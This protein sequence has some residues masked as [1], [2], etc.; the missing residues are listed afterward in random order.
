MLKGGFKIGS[1]CVLVLASSVIIAQNVGVGTTTPAA[2]LHVEVP[3]GFSSPLMQVNVKGSTPY[4]I[5]LPNGKVGIGV[6]TP[7]E[8][9]DVAGNIQFSGA[10]MPGGNA[11]TAG[12]V[13]VSQ[14]PGV[15]PQWQ[16]LSLPSQGDSVCS[17]ALSNYLQK[18]TG[19]ELCN[20]VI[21]DDG[22]NVGIG[23]T[24]PAATLDINGNVR[25]RTINTVAAATPNDKILVANSTGDVL[26]IQF[27]GSNSDYLRGDGTWGAISGGDNWGTQVA[28]TQ[29]PLTGDGT[30]LNPITVQS[31][32]SAGDILVWDGTQWQIQQPSASSGITPICSS[33]TTNF[34]QKWTGTNICNSQIFDD[35]T[36]V[37]I[38]TTT[39]AAKLDVQGT[40]RFTGTLTIGAYTLPNVDGTNGQVLMTDGA[41]NVSWQNVPGDNWGTQTAVTSGP[42]VGNGT[43]GNPITFASGTATGNIWQWN[44]TSWQQVSLTSAV[45]NAGFDSVCSGALAN[46]VQK[47]TGT[48]LCNTRIFD[49]GVNN[50]VGFFTNSPQYPVHIILNY[51]GNFGQALLYVED[52]SSTGGDG[53]AIRGI[54]DRRDYFGYGGYFKGGYKGVYAT[55]TP[56]GSNFYYG[57]DVYVS[58]G[59]GTNYGV[60][61]YASTGGSSAYGVRG[62]AYSSATSGANV[63]GGYF[64]ATS[65]G[66]SNSYGVYAIAGGPSTANFKIGIYAQTSGKGSGHF[67][68]DAYNNV[69]SGT[70]LIARGS[71]ITTLYSLTRGSGIVGISNNIGVFGRLAAQPTTPKPI[72]AIYGV[73]D[74]D[75]VS[76]TNPTPFSYIAMYPSDPNT[77]TAGGYFDD[78]QG[79]YAYVAA[80]VSSIQY[81][82]NGTGSVSTIIKAPDG[83][84]RNMFA[85]EAP[86]ILFMDFGFAQLDN[87]KAVVKLDPIFANT[88]YVSEEKPLRVFTQV[89]GVEDCGTVGLVSYG[90]DYF[91]VQA[92]KPCNAQFMWMVVA[93]R[94]DEY[95]ENGKLISRNQDVRFPI[96]PERMPK[97]KE[98]KIHVPTMQKIEIDPKKKPHDK[99]K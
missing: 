30:T 82:I 85:P 80:R 18:W 51:G 83:T 7:S 8:I 43:A 56:T 94:A 52:T 16:T 63:Y 37:G 97:M 41:G 54:K 29:A 4:I 55:V 13:L 46:Y 26:A 87:G 72:A 74:N 12:Q 44:G 32:T 40:G 88:I 65:S 71:G 1:H 17:S 39:P 68:I 96:S 91:E 31:G 73:A 23:I 49:D 6:A 47:W 61:S 19:T 45:S 33:P 59:T 67:A 10:L 77:P 69:D 5:V 9:L 53:A 42:V 15:T 84:K 38:G 92:T 64:S 34:L 27:T 35:G 86:E 2:K 58:G 57:V 75:P 24:S 50:R 3:A 36:N 60:Y 93:N 98:R 70:A 90:Q 20:S 95:D 62:S 89:M 76:T 28:I 99:I 14:G 81:K 21:Y 78:G 25:I 66:T 79:T 48:E 22:T 11:G